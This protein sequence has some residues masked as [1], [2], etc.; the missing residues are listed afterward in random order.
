MDS[1][2]VLEVWR[3]LPQED[4]DFLKLVALKMVIASPP[5]MQL[6]DRLSH[7]LRRSAFL[8]CQETENPRCQSQIA[9]LAKH[10]ER[11]Q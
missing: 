10:L 7:G 4:R 9:P 8:G 11:L 5:V 1:E 3:R 2:E 6:N